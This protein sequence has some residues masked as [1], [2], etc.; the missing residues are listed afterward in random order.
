MS[1][2][3]LSQ[4][5]KRSQSALATL[6]F[7]LCF[8]C[9]SLAYTGPVDGVYT[10]DGSDDDVQAAHDAASDGNTLA[11]PAGS[12]A[13]DESVIITK[14]VKLVGA[15][16]GRINAY[17]ASAVTFGT[18]TKTFKV[19]HGF[20]LTPGTTLRAWET[21]TDK[22]GEYMLGT[23]TSIDGPTEVFNDAATSSAYLVDFKYGAGTAF[24][25][26]GTPGSA[27]NDFEGFVGFKFTVGGSPITVSHLGRRFVTGNTQN[28]PARI[29]NM[30]G[31]TVSS[32]DITP[33]G[34]V[35]G[36]IK[37]EALGTPV[38]LSAST[39]YRIMV[40]EFTGGDQ[41]L[42]LA[43]SVSTT[44]AATLNGRVYSVMETTATLNATTNTGTGTEP[45][46]LL[47]TEPSTKVIHSAG[48][49]I[50]LNITEDAGVS[51]EVSGIQFSY[52]TGTGRLI[53]WSYAAS[54]QPILVHDNW[55]ALAT[56]RVAC[57][58]TT[59]NKG[60]FWN[61]SVCWNELAQSDSQWLHLPI[62]NRTEV[63]AALSTMGMADT[64]GKSN[65]YVED[66][67]FHGCMVAVDVDS[68]AKIVW[69]NNVH[70]NAG[71]AG[72]GFDTSAYG[73]RHWEFYDNRFLYSDAGDDSLN[74]P[75]HIMQRGGTGVI[76]G[77][78]F[79]D[80][81][82]SA[83]GQRF[84]FQFGVYA[85]SLWGPWEG[86]PSHWSAGDG[87]VV[88]YPAP[89]QFGLGYVTG[90]GVDGKGASIRNGVYVGDAEPVYIWGNTGH[91]PTIQITTDDNGDPNPDNPEDYIQAG[92]DYKL[93]AKPGY[94]K[95]T[96]PHP[97]RG[98]AP[99]PAPANTRK[100]IRVVQP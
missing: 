28:H 27:R 42:E 73:C 86:G 39:A 26:G 89:R 34:G 32:V 55:F 33:A 45:L 8:A 80:I 46:W 93:E 74:V 50:L 2:R 15:G 69:R 61:N 83:Y 7:F 38:V 63:W 24:V 40:Q 57:E 51:T 67:D 10:T 25:T 4:S 14:G 49:A 31:A 13:W 30:A 98:A 79:Q 96:Y 22:D 48:S 5:A 6:A 84:E 54:G 36:T 58:T 11:I 81:A 78:Y 97:L 21:A 20:S 88:E 62:N 35:N 85:L 3:R 29:V 53:K 23:L 64:T 16:S 37:Y 68:N 76:T 94:T 66:N 59:S 65:I 43:T 77:N 18:G 41:W 1:L 47:A 90:T 52:G 71:V 44:G 19:Q 92:R 17:G 9:Q 75:N 56:S 72:H 82:S 91:T 95:Y 87:G 12:F 100:L 60:I 70:N 99:Q